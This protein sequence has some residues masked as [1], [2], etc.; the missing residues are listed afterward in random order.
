MRCRFIPVLISLSFGVFLQDDD[1]YIGMKSY[2]LR[3]VGAGKCHTWG[4]GCVYTKPSIRPSSKSFL[5][6]HLF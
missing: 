5:C 4:G 3:S 2:H 6:L 1:K